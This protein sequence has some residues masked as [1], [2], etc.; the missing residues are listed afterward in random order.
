MTTTVARA[1]L[2]RALPAL[3]IALCACTPAGGPESAPTVPPVL[4]PAP[5][6]TTLPE[7]TATTAPTARALPTATPAPT[8]IEAQVI[9][10]VDGDTIRVSIGGQEYTVRYIG[11]DTP[12]TSHPVVG[13]ERLGEDAAEANR[14]LVEGQTV[15]LEY[16]VSPTDQYGRLLAYVYLADGHM[17]NEELVRLGYAA[18]QAY[19]PD[20]KHQD[21]L[22]AAQ[23]GA[24]SQT[25]NIWE[26]QA[27]VQPEGAHIVIIEYSGGSNPEYIGITNEGDA[28][29]D[30]T[31]WWLLS[32]R[33]NQVFQ[34]PSGYT[35]AP[36]A[37]VRIYS[38]PLAQDAPEDGLLWVKEHMWNNKESDPAELYNA[39]G[40]LVCTAG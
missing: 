27:T 12:E 26:P 19:P 15:Y 3:L 22:D 28:G 34:F 6:A 7:P 35:L 14:Q 39:A 36:G 4:A 5:T 17:V 18:S 11:I 29:A 23:V 33:G 9:E 32:V 20:T 16:D 21:R 8:L 24:R 13:Q 40:E 38:G 1:A 31:G 10:V 2:A 37:S 25:I 30:L